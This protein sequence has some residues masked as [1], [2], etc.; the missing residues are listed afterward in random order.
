[1]RVAIVVPVFN[2]ADVLP[3]FFSTLSKTIDREQCEIIAVDNASTDNS[4][5]LIR[6][7]NP[8]ATIIE[9]R[10]NRG[11]AGA[12]NQ[13]M[14][15]AIHRGAR[16][17]MLANQDL[18]FDAGWLD[19]LVSAL[20]NGSTLGAVQP[21][22]MLYPETHLINSYGN[23]LHYLGFGFT[24]R[25]KTPLSEH[26]PT[27]I[28]PV[29]YCSGAALML[30][31][32]AL[33]KVGVFDED[34]FM[35]HEESDL[36]WRL[37]IAGYH[38]SIV[39]QS[40]VFHQYVFSGNTREKFFLI[41]RNRLTN[42]FK[43][44]QAKTLALIAPMLVLWEL[45]LFFYSIIGV[46]VG[47]KTLGF[48]D[49][50]RVYTHFFRIRTWRSVALWRKK[51]RAFRTVPDRAIVSLFTDTIEFQDV[52]SPLLEKIANPMTRGYWRLIKRFI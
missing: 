24:T 33:K 19:P 12:C 13:G 3:R 11:F 15:L 21:L 22:I 25:Y 10:T 38:P 50:L 40:R 52:K 23:A 35:Y 48:F 9:N 43:N 29:A 1:M 17:V 31:V 34:Y 28:T 6:S 42:L 36:C 39:P 4:R 5:D 27:A 18:S 7:A 30:S 47:K 51:I 20:E 26:T 32:T 44:Y 46:L 8:F 49:K 16:F 41:E 37:R 45:G 2:G 14:R